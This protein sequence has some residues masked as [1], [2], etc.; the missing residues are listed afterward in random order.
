VVAPSFGWGFSP[1]GYYAPAPVVVAGG[2]GGGSALFT[3]LV[4]GIFAFVAYQ[5]ISGSF[6]GGD[7]YDDFEDLDN[8]PMSVVKLQVGLL[9]SARELQRDLNRM[10]NTTDTSTPQGLHYLLQE[11]V[12]SLRRNPQYAV[13][14]KFPM[15]LLLQEAAECQDC[16]GRNLI[17]ES[18]AVSYER[19]RTVARV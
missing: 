13:Y 15:P 18:K 11:T 8:G 1:F 2:G 7:D 3:F 12:L 6:A 16:R 5:A 19:C 17:C 10:G 14:G 9:G 4:L